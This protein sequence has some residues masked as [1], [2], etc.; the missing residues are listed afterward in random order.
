MS[1]MLSLEGELEVLFEAGRVALR[2]KKEKKLPRFV[3]SLMLSVFL[4]RCPI[5]IPHFIVEPCRLRRSTSTE[6][7]LSHGKGARSAP[8]HLSLKSSK[9]KG[10]LQKKGSLFSLLHE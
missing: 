8:A 3:I 7:P 5:S 6:W 1:R 10:L 2:K 4:S 9:S